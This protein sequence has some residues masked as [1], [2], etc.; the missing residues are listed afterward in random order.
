MALP[1][2]ALAI[3]CAPPG[4]SGVDQYFETV[5]GASCNQ[6]PGGGHHGG[7]GGSG[8][9]GGSLSSGTSRQ[10]AAQGAAGRAVANLVATTG[11]APAASR[12]HRGTKPGKNARGSNSTGRSQTPSVTGA[13]PLSAILHPILHGAGSGGLGIVFPIL[14]AVVL[15]FMLGAWTM[16]NLLRRRG[17]NS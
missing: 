5:P 2:N 6:P 16:R 14:L 1:A 8:G 11:T 15:A 17:L 7:T 3:N 9:S 13:N 10:L 4:N 12:S